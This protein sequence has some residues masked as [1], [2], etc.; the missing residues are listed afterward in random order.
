M[1]RISY[2]TK[3]LDNL[4]DTLDARRGITR[5]SKAKKAEQRTVICSAIGSNK[6]ITFYCRGGFRFM[7]PHCFGVLTDGDEALL[8]YQVGGYDRF[9]VLS[10]WKLFR[11]SDI[12]RLGITN[13]YFTYDESGPGP[14][15]D[16]RY[17]AF[18]TIYCQVR[19]GVNHETK[20]IIPVKPK[21]TIKNESPVYEQHEERIPTVMTHNERM[22][23]FRLSHIIFPWRKKS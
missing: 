10:G 15:Y 12:S 7:E 16:S 9:D 5:Q 21:E 23:G 11:S 4:K 14:G 19:P 8:S 18:K 13:E 22:N 1:F 20:P 3:Y 2:L 6:V 17:S